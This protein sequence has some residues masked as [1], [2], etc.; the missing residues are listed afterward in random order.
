M[1]NYRDNSS[2]HIPYA[3]RTDMVL[4]ASLGIFNIALLAILCSYVSS[5]RPVFLAL[6]IGFIYALEIALIALRRATL[7]KI[8]P[9]RNIHSLLSEES[10]V[11]LRN[12]K[13]PVI[14]FDFHG[15]VLW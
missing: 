5:I 8:Q 14:V 6:V 7:S 15:T 3:S 2:M 9:E 1:N 10:S 11:V 12:S 13:S 4:Y